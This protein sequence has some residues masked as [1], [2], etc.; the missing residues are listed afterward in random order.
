M[1]PAGPMLALLVA[2]CLPFGLVEPKRTEVKGA[3]SVEP[4]LAWSRLN[5]RVTD[6]WDFFAPLPVERWTIDGERLEAL[7]FIIG[8]EAG[9]PLLRV[10]DEKDANQPKFESWMSPSDIMD[11]FIAA[12][13]KALKT[14]LPDG[15]DLR[16]VRFADADGFRF[17]LSYTSRDEI[18]RELAAVGAV[19]R[20]KL[21]LIAYQGAR[22]YHY[23]RYLPE[24][25]RIVTS[26]R[27]TGS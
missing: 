3:L 15:R 12:L 4:G 23:G 5:A 2:A 27:F 17:E 18:D 19:H 21:Y 26:A 14:P 9:E 8:V 20:G 25:E 24:F 16:P 10:A 22:L 7:I 1:K 11:L 13:G 6:G